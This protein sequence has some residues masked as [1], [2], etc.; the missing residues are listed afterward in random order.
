MRR[1]QLTPM[2]CEPDA[3]AMSAASP[4]RHVGLGAVVF[5]VRR[6]GNWATAEAEV[7]VPRIAVRPAADGWGKR[8]DLLG[9]GEI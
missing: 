7:G 5:A 9:G 6:L 4:R 3:D 2:R 8:D 1:C